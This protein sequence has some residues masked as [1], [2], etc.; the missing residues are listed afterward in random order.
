MR[1]IFTFMATLLVAATALPPPHRGPGFGA[2]FSTGLSRPSSLQP[3]PGME[4]INLTTSTPL[5]ERS[6]ASAPT[7]DIIKEAVE[8]V[9]HIQNGIDE[10]HAAG[11]I[12]GDAAV[13]VADAAGRI[14]ESASKQDDVTHV[15]G[16]ALKDVS[17]A[18]DDV[19]KGIEDKDSAGEIAVDV[20]GDVAGVLAAVS[21][22]AENVGS[23]SAHGDGDA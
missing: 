15:V 16:E 22:S 18:V 10:K 13:E 7:A 21:H 19:R 5:V 2:A 14:M 9:H 3:R 11:D 4:T 20:V 17:A 12:V 23:E 1:T 6:D 8:T